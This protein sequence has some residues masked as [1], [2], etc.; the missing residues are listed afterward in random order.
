MVAAPHTSNWDFVLMLAMAWR[1][2]I[3]PLWLGKKE[4]FW[5]P[6]GPIFGRLG[7]I[8]VDRENP[9]GL[10]SSLAQR[11]R[12]GHASAIVIPPE[13][14]R[15]R[16]EYWK[17]GFRRIATDAGVPIVLT[18]LDGPTRTGGFGPEFDPSDD[19]TADMDRIRA[20]YADKQGV[21]PGRFTPPLLRE[22]LADAPESTG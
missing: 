2:D 10:A 21:V 5:G 20:F 19:V 12:A 18:F 13:G 14:T 1:N 4:M 7:G 16:G 11:A 3:S 17:S 9:A 22:E 8:A 15:S 6:F